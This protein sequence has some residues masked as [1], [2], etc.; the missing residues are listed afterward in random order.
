ML[1]RFASLLALSSLLILSGCTQHVAQDYP[2]YLSNNRGDLVLPKTGLKA[3]Y[4]LT[5]QSIHY[6]YTVKS[7][8]AGSANAWVVEPGKM[9]EATLKSPEV[10]GAFDELE[11]KSGEKGSPMVLTFNINSYKFAGFRAIAAIHVTAAKNGHTVLDKDYYS[12]GNSQGGKMF[13]GGALGMKNAIQQSTKSA[14]DKIMVQL[15]NDLRTQVASA[16]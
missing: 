13:W 6:S 14:Y 9:L 11:H 8:L 7:A 16:R 15:I 4:A 12:N 5:R 10:R 1:K 2:Q 3:Q